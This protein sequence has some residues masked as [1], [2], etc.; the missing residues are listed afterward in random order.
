MK[1]CRVLLLKMFLSPWAGTELVSSA[2]SIGPQCLVNHW[3]KIF[4][5]WTVLVFFPRVFW[6]N[7][8]LGIIDWLGTGWRSGLDLLVAWGFAN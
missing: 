1:K 4:S 6:P 5:C 3:M 7:F 8:L 2:L